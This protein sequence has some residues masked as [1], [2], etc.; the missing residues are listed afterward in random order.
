MSFHSYYYYY[1]HH[2]YY[3]LPFFFLLSFLLSLI[4]NDFTNNKHKHKTHTE[5]KTKK[6][7][8]SQSHHLSSPRVSSW[9]FLNL[10]GGLMLSHPTFALVPLFFSFSF[11]IF[12]SLKK[13]NHTQSAKR[14]RKLYSASF[15]PL[16]H[17]TSL[18]PFL[19]LPLRFKSC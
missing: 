16:H 3:S 11:F 5:N 18:S 17:F 9:T 8:S 10:S 4:S 6:K 15:L 7:E 12:L 1:Y 13:A 19:P 2:Q 14:T